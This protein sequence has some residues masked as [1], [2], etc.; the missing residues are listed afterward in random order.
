MS[1]STKALKAI[2]QATLRRLRNTPTY[3]VLIWRWMAWVYALIW[4]LTSHI[5]LNTVLIPLGITLLIALI[6]TLYAPVFQVFIPR[7]PVIERFRL[8]GQKKP[9]LRERQRSMMWGFRRNRPIAQDE[10]AAIV[11][12]V[13]ST[14][15]RYGDILIYGLDVIICG[16]IVYFT[17]TSWNPPYGDGSPFYRY[18]LSAILA[19]SFAYR[20]RG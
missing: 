2:P 9:R 1:Q 14:R 7:M 11:T 12:Q 13:V 6:G 15:N 16:L 17:A 20:Y 19:A 5:P 8:P 4:Y 18:G 3:F 10:E